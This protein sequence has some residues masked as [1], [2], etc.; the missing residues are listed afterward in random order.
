ME[1]IATVISTDSRGLLV[2]DSATGNE[3][4]VNFNNAGAFR[5]GDI[6]RILYTGT[7]T[8]SIPPQITATS[9]TRW[10]TTPSRPTPMPP[11]QTNFSEIRRATVLQVRRDFLLVRDPANN[12]RQVGVNYSYAHHFC[13]GQRVNIR[14]ETAFIDSRLTVNATD[15]F[16]VC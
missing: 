8:L 10:N 13:V 6:V 2:I 9:V 16:P 11:Q 15:V 4:F 5:P 7:M 1:M 3:V 14:Y 12:N